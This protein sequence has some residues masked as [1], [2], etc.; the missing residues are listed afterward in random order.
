MASGS[1]GAF[2][3][4]KVLP[5]EDRLL[6]P[7]LSS[8]Q[9]GDE[10]EEEMAEDGRCVEC[11]GLLGLFIHRTPLFNVCRLKGDICTENYTAD[12]Q[13]DVAYMLE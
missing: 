10:G 7:N 6:A 9:W 5:L 12:L 3:T 1:Y 8:S 2:D 4:A 13:L 11:A